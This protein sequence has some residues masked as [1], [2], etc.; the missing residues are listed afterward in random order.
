MVLLRR[1]WM[2]QMRRRQ[3]PTST[4]IRWFCLSTKLFRT[5]SPDCRV[6]PLTGASIF[7][8]VPCFFDFS[9]FLFSII[10]FNFFCF[11]LLMSVSHDM[12]VQY[13]SSLWTVQI[14]FSIRPNI[15]F[16]STFQPLSEAAKVKITNSSVWSK[17][18]VGTFDQIT[19]LYLEVAEIA[20]NGWTSP[21]HVIL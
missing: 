12:E 8:L 21:L 2:R 17:K 13:K 4:L 1:S 9:N 16:T 5:S 3:S 19:V 6:S 18:S 10:F 15:F 20:F 14:F 11:I 7:T